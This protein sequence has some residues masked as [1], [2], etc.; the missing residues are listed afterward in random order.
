MFEGNIMSSQTLCE[1][2]PQGI[3][4]GSCCLIC[5]GALNA[6]AMLS[7][8][9]TFCTDCLQMYTTSYQR[10]SYDGDVLVISCPTCLE[11]TQLPPNGGGI[12]ELSVTNSENLGTFQDELKKMSMVGD[13]TIKCDVC[14]FKETTVDCEYYCNKCQLHLCKTCR[15]VHNQQNIFKDHAV[16]HISTKEVLTVYCDR[17][18]NAQALYFCIECN[19]PT[20]TICI[21]QGH[22]GH[23]LTR[24][25]DALV[26]HRDTLRTVLNTLQQRIHQTEGLVDKIDGWVKKH[27]HKI[28]PELADQLEFESNEQ[29]S[30]LPKH[31]TFDGDKPR[32]ERRNSTQKQASNLHAPSRKKS[33]LPKFFKSF[34]SSPVP[35][36]KNGQS[37]SHRKSRDDTLCYEIEMN[38]LSENGT[39]LP[40]TSL[41]KDSVNNGR[42]TSED[43]GYR[44]SSNDSNGSHRGSSTGEMDDGIIPSLEREMGIDIKAVNFHTDIIR[45]MFDLAMKATE[46]SQSRYLLVLYDDILARIDVILNTDI[47]QVLNDL[48]RSIKREITSVLTLNSFMSNNNALTG[49]VDT[50]ININQDSPSHSDNGSNPTLGSAFDDGEE[51]CMLVKPELLWKLEKTKSDPGELWNPVSVDFLPGGNVVVAEYDHHTTKN[52]RLRLFDNEGNQIGTIAHEKVN[53]LGLTVTLDGNIAVT[54]CAGKRVKVYSPDGQHLSEWGKGQFGWPY[55]ITSNSRGQFIVSDTFNDTISIHGPDGRKIKQFGGSGHNR[56]Q[57]KNPYHLTVDEHDNIIVSDCGNH[58]VKIF[59]SQGKFIR[60]NSRS[61]HSEEASPWAT[62]SGRTSGIR[63]GSCKTSLKS[64]RGVCV[65]PKGNILVADDRGRVCILNNK[66]KFERNLLTAEDGV[67]FAEDLAVNYKGQLA[68]TEWNPS[69]MFAIKVFGVYEF[70]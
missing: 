52:S 14:N 7:C 54:D 18:N 70:M 51:M 5:C 6:P 16:I 25:R 53:P 41:L 10:T 55:G 36:R 29:S 50:G 2:S 31:E 43:S 4:D 42:K 17:H 32:L 12:Q 46:M 45:R 61:S 28:L 64:P 67:Y 38:K 63:S 58:C 65:D 8:G 1:P 69:N 40:S 21:F 30:L 56:Y 13:S 68:V 20:C 62:F 39:A 47:P 26:T 49:S 33:I 22:P 9:H 3:D 34:R 60:M 57:F 27:L 66:A 48:N 15:N 59:D 37:K 23:H 24:L 19:L 35:K 44:K 11:N